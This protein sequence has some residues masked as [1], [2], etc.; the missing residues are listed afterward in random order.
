MRSNTSLVGT[1]LTSAY[2]SAMLTSSV[3]PIRNSSIFAAAVDPTAA[4]KALQDAVS[5]LDASGWATAVANTPSA[6]P[7]ASNIVPVNDP[8]PKA[9]PIM[10]E[11][12]MSRLIIFTSTEGANTFMNEKLAGV[13]GLNDG[14]KKIPV[15]QVSEPV[16]DGKHF[17]M[18]TTKEGSTDIVLGFKR[19]TGGDTRAYLTDKSGV[20]RAAA[21]MSFQ[22]TRLITNEQAAKDYEAEMRLFAKLAKDLPPTSTA[23]AGN[24]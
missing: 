10:T 24:S 18:V 19:A 8:A 9:E 21:I 15:M 12:L 23:V 1:I 7:P 14:T 22:G 4:H 5:G 17:F 6:P 11:E 20:L 13:F 3:A 16:P 2:L